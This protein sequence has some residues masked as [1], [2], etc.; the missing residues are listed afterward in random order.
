MA[1][2]SYTFTT[3]ANYTYNSSK[4]EFSGGVAQLLT[5]ATTLNFNEDFADDTGH[6]YNSSVTEF[7]GG[8]V[9]QKDATFGAYMGLSFGTDEEPESWSTGTPDGVLVSGAV[10]NAGKLECLGNATAKYLA[11]TSLGVEALQTGTIVV[12]YTPNYSG[13]PTSTDKSIVL[14]ERAS[15]N[16]DRINLYHRTTGQLHLNCAEGISTLRINTDLAAWSP[17]SGTE[18]TFVITYDFTAGSTKVYL[19]GVQQGSTQTA[20]FTRTGSDRFYLGVKWAAAGN[21]DAYYDDVLLFNTVKDYTL[22]NSYSV[23]SGVYSE[24]A[25]T[26]PEFEYVA[27]GSGITGINTLTTTEANTPKYTIQL[28]RSGNYL[29]WNGSAWATS[30]GTFSQSTSKAD[31]TSKTDFNTNAGSLSITDGTYVQMKA[32]FEASAST[33]MS[34]SDLTLNY[35]GFGYVGDN[36]TLLTNSLFYVQDIAAFAS[37]VT[38][39]GSDA[40]KFAVVQN[41]TDKYWDGAAWATSTGYAQTN[42]SSEV[43]TNITSLTLAER[44]SI[45]LKIYLHSNDGSSTPTID[46]ATF[47]YTEGLPDPTL[48]TLVIVHGFLYDHDGPLA[49]E[50]IQVRPYSEGHLQNGVFHVYDWKDYDTTNAD[51]Y[52]QGLL[53]ANVTGE[54]WEFKIGKQ[55]Y[56][57]TVP[58]QESVDFSTLTLTKI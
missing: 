37:V 12:K 4:I 23:P 47:T 54:Q 17:T 42:S 29:Y 30:D 46:S 57:F 25:V 7:T 13:S 2:K 31:S 45:G 44:D 8:L 1:T 16:G 28:N 33:Q 58:D 27:P 41:G 48:S 34:V 50:L 14:L 6:T 3:P 10:V 43:V 26:L 40:V 20:T 39:T 36:P 21:A 32:H 18:Y 49:S 24:D 19:D 52:F 56:R 53:Y 11:V 15:N 38:E 9:R 35:D 55:R 51:G 22:F 5:A